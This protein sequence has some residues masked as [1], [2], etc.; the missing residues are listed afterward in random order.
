MADIYLKGGLGNQFFQYVFGLYLI[1]NGLTDNVILKSNPFLNS[2]SVLEY[3]NITLPIQKYT[4]S[5]AIK[6]LATL[7]GHL[8]NHKAL[9]RREILH[10]QKNDYTGKSIFNGYWQDCYY[11][12]EIKHKIFTDLKYKF[13]LS[14]NAEKL[15]NQISQT[16]S[17]VF[18]GVRLGDYEI[19]KMKKKYGKIDLK[20][21][22][23][24][25]EYIERR[26]KTPE[27][28][29]FSN[30]MR[31]VKKMEIFTKRK[32]FF[33]DQI[34]HDVEEFEVMRSCKHF[35]IMNSTFH[36]WSAFLS[37]TPGI[38]IC[39]KKWFHNGWPSN[40]KLEKWINL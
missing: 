13:D 8:L 30:D 10:Y 20:Y 35:I 28:Y 14:Y 38:V 33:V 32:V 16:S 3:Y 31:Q 17:S 9:F 11:I 7:L 36:W 19:K 23:E 22:L 40:L 24:A 2:P 27:Y 21:F 26:V 25:F 29:V 12:E 1:H 4:E 37:N 5:S 39:P 34:Q 18:V 6:R 15:K